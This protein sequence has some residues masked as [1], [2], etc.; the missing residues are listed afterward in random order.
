MSERL[1][2]A[3]FEYLA[4]DDTHRPYRQLGESMTLF[5]L[6]PPCAEDASVSAQID[7]IHDQLARDI[8]L[9]QRDLNALLARA[10]RPGL[11]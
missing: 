9:L 10:R 2:P 4:P 11:G 1:G 6:R 3:N 7:D 8:P 5:D